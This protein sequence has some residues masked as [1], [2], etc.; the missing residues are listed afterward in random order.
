MRKSH[1]KSLHV[2]YNEEC[3]QL[4]TE[5]KNQPSILTPFQEVKKQ[6][7]F[8][9]TLMKNQK[10]AFSNPKSVEIHNLISQMI[11]LQDC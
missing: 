5:K 10:W 11:A 4:E 7:I 8:K 9:D 1:L 2:T 6:M 3:I